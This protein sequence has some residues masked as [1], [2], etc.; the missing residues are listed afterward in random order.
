MLLHVAEFALRLDT[1]RDATLD[2]EAA[3]HDS[4]NRERLHDEL[5]ACNT[6]LGALAAELRDRLSVAKR[7][8]ANRGDAAARAV[9]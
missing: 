1:A 6:A 7:S 9:A 4:L 3:P 5:T 8:A 2:V